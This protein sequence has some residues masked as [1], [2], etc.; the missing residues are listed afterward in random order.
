MI[1]EARKKNGAGR[2]AVKRESCRKMWT[3]LEE[4]EK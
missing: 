2:G 1:V 3:T 4:C